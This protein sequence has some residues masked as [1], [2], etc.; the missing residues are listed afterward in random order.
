LLKAG[1]AVFVPLTKGPL[2]FAI[3]I[4]LV[5]NLFLGEI[6]DGSRS[7]PRRSCSS[8]GF[9]LCLAHDVTGSAGK[10]EGKGRPAKQNTAGDS[11]EQGS[12]RDAEPRVYR[13]SR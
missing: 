11:R 7:L 3:H 8:C 4:T 2:S 6:R 1:D 5:L 10:L 9:W 12:D 13:G